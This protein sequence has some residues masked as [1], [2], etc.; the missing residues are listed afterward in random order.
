MTY[1]GVIY[2][3]AADNYGLVTTTQANEV[4]ATNKDLLCY[5][6]SGRLDWLG[7]GAYRITHYMPIPNDPYAESVALVSDGAHLYGESVIA[8]HGLAHTNP[9]RIFVATP[10]RVRRGLPDGLIV[11]RRADVGDVT[12]YEGMPSQSIPAAIGACK[13]TVLPERLEQVTHRAAGLGL[14]TNEEEDDLMKKLAL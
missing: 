8:M 9:A 4:G 7:C 10:K 12:S 13:P 2:E 14:I 1:Y 5:V 3:I 6:K 11:K